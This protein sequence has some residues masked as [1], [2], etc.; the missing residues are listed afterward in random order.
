MPS[1]EIKTLI[2]RFRDLSTSSGETITFHQQVIADEE[3][4]WWG[5]WHKDGETVPDDAFRTVAKAAAAA[6]G[7]EVLL[8]HSDQ[9]KIFRATCVKVFWDNELHPTYPQERPELVPKYYKGRPCLAWFRF[10]SIIPEPLSESSLK[11]LS[12]VEVPEFFTGGEPGYQLFDGKVI[13]STEELRQ[14][15]RTIWFVRAKRDGD[16]THEIKLFDAHQIVPSDFPKEHIV[17][18]STDLLWVSDLHFSDDGHHAFTIKAEGDRSAWESIKLQLDKLGIERVA[19]VIASGD[20]AWKAAPSEFDEARKSFFD[21]ALAWSKELKNYHFLVC[22]RNHDLR[23]SPSPEPSPDKKPQPVSVAP[24]EAR[25][26]YEAF[27]QNLYFKRP[28]KFISCG[29]RLLLGGAV[30]VEIACL[31]SCFLDQRKDLFQGQGFVGEKQM[32]DAARELGWVPRQKGPRGPRAVR[33]VVLHHHLLPVSYSE[34]AY[35]GWQYSVTLDAESLMRWVLEHD[36]DLV[37]HGHQ[38]QPFYTQVIR[39]V[40]LKDTDTDSRTTT[41][42]GMGSTGVDLGHLGEKRN[43]MFALLQFGVQEVRIRFF[44][45]DRRHPSEDL[46]EF[47]VDLSKRSRL[48]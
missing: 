40:N 38:H 4:V 19:G 36:V 48:A 29:R 6:S 39:S 25:A 8:F 27:Y 28:N 13:A 31:N 17:S 24:E 9:K 33:I 43:N 41:I 32:Q 47:R 16:P 2:L 37:L 46:F 26:A 1:S 5:W 35:Q 45:I 34:A 18:S 30:P 14:Q 20:F 3:S 42:V 44:S 11:D 22:P 21:A 7:L 10:T 23:F 12:Y 15:S